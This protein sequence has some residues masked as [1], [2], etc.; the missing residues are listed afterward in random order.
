MTVQSIY[1][2]MFIIFKQPPLTSWKEEIF[3]DTGGI[4][5]V[6]KTCC[7]VV[8]APDYLFEHSCITAQVESG[9]QAA[10][11]CGGCYQLLF[12]KKS[13]TVLTVWLKFSLQA[14]M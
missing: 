11:P 10:P 8:F 13:D 9:V 6:R 12:K 5:T 2:F 14:V 1:V 4:I 7:N 3:N